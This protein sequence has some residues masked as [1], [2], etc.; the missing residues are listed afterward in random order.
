MNK[1]FPGHQITFK[2]VQEYVK[3]CPTCQKVRLLTGPSHTPMVRHLKVPHPR[4]AVG[5]DTITISP[6]DELGNL[7][8]D[9]IVNHFTGL[10]FG[11][12]K[13]KHDAESAAESLL[14]YISLYGLFDTIYTDPGSDYTSDIITHLRQYLGYA[15]RFSLVDRHESNGVE[16]SHKELLRHL[17][18]ICNDKRIRHRWSS[19]RVFPFVCY[20]INSHFS[21]ERNSINHYTLTFESL[22]SPYFQLP[23][24]LHAEGA[25]RY[26]RQLNNNLQLV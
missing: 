14:Q 19:P 21:S 25:Q 22:N 6:R 13:G 26:I 20:L 4:A 9:S 18:A 12:P 2:T 5:M 15:H 3:S 16:P 24:Q 8:C 1:H 17:I 7:Y 11:R 23:A 10:F